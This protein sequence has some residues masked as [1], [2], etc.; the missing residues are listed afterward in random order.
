MRELRAILLGE[1]LADARAKDRAHRLGTRTS[2]R[3]VAGYPRLLGEW[4]PT[5]N[6]DLFPDEVTYGSGKLIWW[7]C[8]KGPD[9]VWC[10]APSDRTTRKRG[11]PCC[12]NRAVSVTNSLATLAPDV[13]KELHPTR[14]GKLTAQTAIAKSHRKVWWRC[15]DDAKHVWRAR[16]ANRWWE[17]SGCPFCSGQ[18]VTSVNALAT[19]FPALAAEWDRARNGKLAA[20]TTAAGSRLKV[21]WRCA[22][23]PAHRWQARID[24]RARHQAGCPVCMGKAPLPRGDRKGRLNSLAQRCPEVAAEWD[25][26]RNGATKPKGVSFGSHF[27]AWWRCARNARHRWVAAVG[28][29]SRGSGC[30]FCV[31]KRRL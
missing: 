1:Q 26:S 23:D 6:G 25:I 10:A 7:T 19:N 14:N 15:A 8:P 13:A 20:R 12:A 28:E 11:C 22:R 16:L 18:R 27:R 9:H 4:H 29:R 5:K 31:G 3:W 21:W 24:D 30:P 17:Q 2:T